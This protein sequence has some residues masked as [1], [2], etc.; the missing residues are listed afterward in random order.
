MQLPGSV[1]KRA[2]LACVG[3][4]ALANLDRPGVIVTALGDGIN[5]FVSCYFAPAKRGLFK[6][7]LSTQWTIFA[8]SS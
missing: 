1:E 7:W 8:P 5:D 4:A 2:G 6:S 3:S